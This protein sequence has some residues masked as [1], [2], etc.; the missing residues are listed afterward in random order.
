M[1]RKKKSPGDGV[2]MR[3]FFRI[4]IHEHDQEDPEAPPELVG[5]SG[6]QENTITNN[7]YDLY[8]ARVL[9]GVSGSSLANYCALG[10]GTAPAATDTALL[11]EL[12]DATNCRAALTPTTTGSKTV[13]YSFNLASSRVTANR[14]IQNI[15]LFGTSAVT[16][17]SVFAGNTYATSS[18]ASNQSV[19]GSYEIRFS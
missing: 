14:T 16:V 9:A 17:G 7:G 5:D 8:I 6:W 2:R 15:G 1:A 11:G 18:L 12:T 3:G 4:Q 10:T 19:S 13:S